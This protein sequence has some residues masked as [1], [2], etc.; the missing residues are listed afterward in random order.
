MPRTMFGASRVVSRRCHAVVAPASVRADDFY[1]GKTISIIVGG[2]PG[3]GYGAYAR[4]LAQ[5]LPN[6]IPGHPTVIAQSMPGAGNLNPIRSLA[7]TEPKDGTVMAELNSG[8]LIQSIV[9]PEL[10][11]LDFQKYAWIGMGNSDFL[12]LLR[13]MVPTASPVGR[14]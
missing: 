6:H 13:L 5:F 12:R 4:V 8:V 7:A 11:N 2:S 1:K 14:T 10:I 9:Q 3:G